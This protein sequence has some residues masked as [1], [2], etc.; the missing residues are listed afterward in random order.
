MKLCLNDSRETTASER[1]RELG[2]SAPP[3]HARIHI[4]AH[5][6]FLREDTY[7]SNRGGVAE[8]I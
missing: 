5:P 1:V 6:L 3:P 8:K 4:H 7:T 2:L